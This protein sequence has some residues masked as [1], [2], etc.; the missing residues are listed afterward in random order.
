M[1]TET[2]PF[3]WYWYDATG[4]L[5]ITG[6]DRKPDVPAEAKP[7]YA[8]PPPEAHVRGEL[9]EYFERQID[10]SRETFGPALRT[11]GVID[12]IRKE[13]KEIEQDPHDLS[14][15][16]DVVIL[17]MDGFWRHGG[18]AFDLLPALLAKQRKNMSRTW[19]DWRGMSEDSAIEHDRSKDA[20]LEAAL[21]GSPA[22]KDHVGGDRRLLQWDIREDRNAYP[23]GPLAKDKAL[24]TFTGWE[25]GHRGSLLLIKEEADFVRERLT[26]ANPSPSPREE[27]Q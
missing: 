12:H 7:L 8:S 21:A 3:A 24:Y 5:F 20:A 23:K 9:V 26:T 1:S 4:C 17:A 6:D 15:W 27:G 14:E 13:L 10:W 11:N 22:P 18:K 25:G 2:K 19:P 16:V